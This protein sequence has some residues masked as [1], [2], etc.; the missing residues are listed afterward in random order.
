[1]FDYKKLGGSV[2]RDMGSTCW[3]LK[4]R[5]Q[6]ICTSHS[7]SE[8]IKP[9][10]DEMVCESVRAIR[11]LELA[12]FDR[13]RVHASQAAAYF[14]DREMLSILQNSENAHFLMHDRDC[15]AAVAIQ[16]ALSPEEIAAIEQEIA[17][18]DARNAKSLT[19]ESDGDLNQHQGDE[20][21]GSNA[22][23]YV[24]LKR[25]LNRFFHRKTNSP[26]REPPEILSTAEITFPSGSTIARLTRQFN[27]LKTLAEQGDVSAQ[28]QLGMRYKDGI[29]VTK[30]DKLAAAAFLAAA[31]QGHATAQSRLGDMYMHGHGVVQD[32]AEASYWIYTS[33]A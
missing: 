1:M 25:V 21:T 13:S 28:Y 2:E 29:G 4:L 20:D 31:E 19:G 3:V 22:G 5:G 16:K 11:A 6:T 24:G 33:T 9:M 27:K 23:G 30:D 12:Q 17:V 8:E 14:G 15:R 10:V 26:E 32:G 18:R 7:S